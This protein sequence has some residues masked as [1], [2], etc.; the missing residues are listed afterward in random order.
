MSIDNILFFCVYTLIIGWLLPK[1]WR[2]WALLIGSMLAVY[3]L[4]PSTPIRHLDFWLPTA[5][6]GLTVFVWAVTTRRK[7]E[8]QFQNHIAVIIIL[9]IIVFV[10]ILRYTGQVC[11]ITATRPPN[12]LSILL[13][14]VFML[15]ITAIPYYLDSTKRF[16]TSLSILII[17]GLFIL[18][19]TEPLAQSSSFWLRNITGQSTGLAS[20]VDI[21]WLGFSYLA[22]RLIH[23]LR[24]N[25]LGRLPE[26]SLGE[27]V[28][29]A[30][31]FPTYIAG[32][33]DRI[34]RLLPELRQP[35]QSEPNNT[36]LENTSN[37]FPQPDYGNWIWGGRR[38]L[39][40]TFKKF[41]IADSLALIA[42]NEVNAT[43]VNSSVWAWVMLYAFAFRIYFDFSG[44]TD[45]VL[46]IGRL[47]DFNLPE[48]FSRPYL[49]RN[50]T[51]F[52]N[53]WHI[54]LAQ[55][56]RAYY[57][58]PLTRYLRTRMQPLPLWMII[59][60]GQFSTML[61]IGLWHGVSW[62]F[63]IWGAWHGFGL[64]IHNRWSDWL[65]SKTQFTES[66]KNGNRILQISGWLLTFNYVSLGW[67]WFA[68]SK[69]SSA[70]G[71]F[72]L[73]FGF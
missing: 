21:T 66:S 69:P 8:S 7:T 71:M 39:V 62:N 73:L 61:L 31:F 48:N 40:G 5:S 57:F 12:L 23:V 67:V 59:L 33:I 37:R 16:L 15:G 19:K 26:Y 2:L 18:L 30:I 27:F 56:F 54:T 52:W 70:I 64:F 47:A 34:Q 20:A 17:L 51:A 29:Y 14:S 65:R 25:Q 3:W 32:P 44:Y 42:L 4:H 63:A 11:C 58:N 36:V 28:T 38:I 35:A 49:K 10:G 72:Q 41:V 1:R 53:S 46:G 55:W 9:I 50:L 45:I 22:F 60:V 24:D 13:A 6:I 43:Q 68:L